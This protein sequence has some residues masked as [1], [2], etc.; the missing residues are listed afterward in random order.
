MTATI[1]PKVTIIMPVYNA[2]K[3]IE[4]SLRSLFE[5]TFEDIEYIIVNDC[6]QDNSLKII[7]NII[8]EYPPRNKQVK[9]IN[10]PTNQGVAS[11][12]ASGLNAATGT[13][14]IQIDSDDYCEAT[15]IE[16][17]YNEAVKNTADIV[18]C[19]YYINFPNKQ[20]Y[21]HLSV[22]TNKKECMKKLLNGELMG[23]MWNKLIKNTLYT[24]N[25]LNFI[26]GR[27]MW[28]DV[29]LCI[30]LYFYANKIS[31]LPRAFYHYTQENGN[32]YIATMSLQSLKNIEENV[33]DIELFLEKHNVRKELASHILYLQLRAK[34]EYLQNTQGIKQK[35]YNNYYKAANVAIWSHP[36]LPLHYKLALCFARHKMLFVSNM[37][38]WGL[39]KIKK[40]LR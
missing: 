21:R 11:A 10:H 30:Q 13:Y 23:F 15:M 19:D 39:K 38:F 27:N 36:Y 33:A 25:N 24:S 28:E 20:I 26:K 12:R 35:K 22:G 16:E 14:T 7:K 37:L 5:Q 6:S 17:L 8:D 9:I 31:Y 3:Y 1:T 4:R 40:I 2:E 29:T 32:S 34:K 18:M